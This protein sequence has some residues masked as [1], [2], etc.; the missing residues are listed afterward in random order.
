MSTF[1]EISGRSVE[2]TVSTTTSGAKTSPNDEDPRSLERMPIF[3]TT[4]P[5]A[6]KAPLAMAK[7]VF[8]GGDYLL[9]RP[10]PQPPPPINSRTTMTIRIISIYRSF[11][12]IG[13]KFAPIFD[14]DR[15]VPS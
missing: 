1:D 11:D 3:F 12:R 13:C 4:A 14:I 10:Y 15:S 6:I 8:T 7:M 9:R 5:S 2:E